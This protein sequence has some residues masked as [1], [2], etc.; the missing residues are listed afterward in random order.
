MAVDFALLPAEAPFDE[1]P[2]SKLMWGIVFVVM[3]A[4]GAGAVLLFWPKGIPTNTWQFWATLVVFPIGMPGFLVLRRFSSF[5]GRKL[6]VELRNEATRA[7]NERVFSA[8]SIP[9][10]VLGAAYRYSADAKEN[11]I[12]TVQQGGAMLKT[13]VPIALA[14]EPVRARWLVAPKMRTKPGD[15]NDDLIRQR[16]VTTWLF[17]E[18]LVELLPSLQA[19]PPSVPLVAQLLIANGH[20][21]EQNKQLLEE[22]WRAKQG[23]PLTVA[24]HAEPTADLDA[25]DTWMDEVLGG[26]GTHA[27]LVIAMQ[28][29]PLLASVPP[30]DATEAG[31]A[32]LLMPDTLA[33]QHRVSRIANLHRPVRSPV[34][35]PAEALS[36][37]LRWAGVS[38]AQIKAG[39]QTG[40][41]AKQIGA[42]REPAVKLGLTLQATDVD[43]TIGNAGIAAPWL[44]LA[45]AA[46]SLTEDAPE[47]I[48]FVS[49]GGQFDCAVVKSASTASTPKASI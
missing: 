30:A 21:H 42:L 8:A 18:I 49:Q 28:L 29:H 39:W 24:P 20:P 9:L 38:A 27:T 44:A 48:V 34:A 6:D 16:H 33:S 23:R 45:C 46:S 3:T 17:D 10:A 12:Q 26:T 43:R 47:Q 15:T 36:T 22:R 25:L 19:F 11:A 14:A 4:L 13:Q 41:D 2:P 5:E 40:L 1:S 31:V 35:Q 7:L 37:A 32:I